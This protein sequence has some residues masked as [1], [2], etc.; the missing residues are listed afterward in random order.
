MISYEPVCLEKISTYIYGAREDYVRKR[1]RPLRLDEEYRSLFQRIAAGGREQARS[2]A[3]TLQNRELHLLCDYLYEEAKEEE[4]LCFVMTLCEKMNT[5]LAKSLYCKAQEYY[6]DKRLSSVYG[7]LRTNEAFATAF[8]TLYGIRPDGILKSFE[9]GCSV[10]YINSLAGRSGNNTKLSY[11]DELSALGID[12]STKLYLECTKLYIVVCDAKEYLSIGIDNLQQITYK[13]EPEFQEKLL[14]NMLKCLD[15]YQM[16]RFFPMLEIFKKL[17]GGQDTKSFHEVMR[18][19]T[20]EQVDK[21]RLWLNQYQI[22]R[23]LGNSERA[24][25]WL[26]YTKS[27]TTRIHAPSGALLLTFQDFTV[28]EFKSEDRVA[29]F[30]DNKYFEHIVTEGIE[31]VTSEATLED[32]LYKNTQW[33]AQG[34]HIGHWRKAHRGNWKLDMKEYIMHRNVQA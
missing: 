7:Y 20:P 27:C 30:Y 1:E 10:E 23:V 11:M 5:S 32:W 8:F 28:I 34:E 21:Y 6:D 14:R 2:W 19:L 9:Q 4:G 18:G 22:W 15:N 33:G 26:N 13:M 12:K 25:F 16:R 3:Y 24:D 31:T 29:Y 17:T